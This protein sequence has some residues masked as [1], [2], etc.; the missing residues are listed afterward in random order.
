MINLLINLWRFVVGFFKL[1]S[2][3]YEPGWGALWPKPF[4]LLYLVDYG[5]HVLTGGAV[6]SWSRWAW[7]NRERYVLA[8]WLHDWLGAKHTSEAGPVLWDTKDCSATFRLVL[9][10][11]WIGFGL[12]LWAVQ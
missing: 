7:D 10:S 11:L 4:V 3:K 9:G 5:T 6:V 8:E 1:G 2:L 12:W